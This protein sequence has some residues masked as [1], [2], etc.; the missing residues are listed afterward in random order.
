MKNKDGNSIELLVPQLCR[1]RAAIRLQMKYCWAI[2]SETSIITSFVC[3]LRTSW[4][5]GPGI[6]SHDTVK[7]YVYCKILERLRKRVM[8]MRPSRAT[9]CCIMAVQQQ[10]VLHHGR[11]TTTGAASWP[12]NSNWM[13]HHGRAT[14]T[15]A[16]SWPCNSNWCCIM[17][18]QQQLVLHH[19]RATATGAASWP[20]NSNWCC[21]MAMRLAT[22]HPQ[23]LCS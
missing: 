9:G 22:H 10:L 11:A 19:G 3:C 2:V 13:L 20:C 7:R 23:L 16:A 21:I 18:V 12:C 8:L 4:D 14:A 5:S 6:R 17:A 1:K 15:G